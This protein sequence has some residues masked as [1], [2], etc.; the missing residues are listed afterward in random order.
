L[1][2]KPYLT[3]ASGT[4]ASYVEPGLR[5]EGKPESVRLQ[6]FYDAQTSGGLLISVPADRADALV[7]RVREKGASSACVVGE[8]QERGDKALVVRQ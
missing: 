7:A 2:H 4:N 5:V 1:A 6:F 8:I 3:R